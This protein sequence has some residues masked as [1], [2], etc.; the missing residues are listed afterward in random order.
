MTDKYPKTFAPPTAE[1][2]CPVEYEQ[3]R[4]AVRDGKPASANPYWDKGDIWQDDRRYWW[5]R[6]WWDGL[7]H[8]NEETL[9]KIIAGAM[10]IPDRLTGDP[11][12]YNYSSARLSGPHRR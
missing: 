10:A 3:G 4:D 5:N 12:D 9:A 6:G 8:V 7:D 11:Q 2:M 1:I